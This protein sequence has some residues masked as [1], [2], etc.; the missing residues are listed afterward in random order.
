MMHVFPSERVRN[1]VAFLA[2]LCAIILFFLGIYQFI[3]S[4]REKEFHEFRKNE[5]II[6]LKNQLAGE[7]QS[8]SERGDAAHLLANHGDKAIPVFLDILENKNW[9]SASPF[10]V[11]ALKQIED[12]CPKKVWEFLSSH[13]NKIIQE[14]T[15]KGSASK[16]TYLM[17]GFE[18]IS[19]M[20][21]SLDENQIRKFLDSLH[22]NQAKC[23]GPDKE[24]LENS[25]LGKLNGLDHKGICR[26]IRK[27][28][29]KLNNPSGLSRLSHAD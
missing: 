14:A 15:D 17:N 19:K 6:A 20:G 4:Q 1:F 28:L 5:K 25:P 21:K 24:R 29:T 9:R 23:H 16:V 18:L 8:P 11:K 26:G 22:E 3:E 12:Q 2:A 27:A 13:I 7:N 10:V